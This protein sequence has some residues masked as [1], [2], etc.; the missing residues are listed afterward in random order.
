[1]VDFAHVCPVFK[2]FDSMTDYQDSSP[3]NNNH[4]TCFIQMFG[5]ES[6][7]VDKHTITIFYIFLM[8]KLKS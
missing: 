2:S 6:L 8:E 3:S 1:M 4:M 5:L 7:S